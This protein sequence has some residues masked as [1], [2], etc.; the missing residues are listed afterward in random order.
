[1]CTVPSGA[2]VLVVS[3][4]YI[5]HVGVVSRVQS[6]LYKTKKTSLRGQYMQNA[7]KHG[8]ATP[9]ASRVNYKR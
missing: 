5:M 7:F 1:M 4:F 2:V 3:F 8:F 6:A 9:K